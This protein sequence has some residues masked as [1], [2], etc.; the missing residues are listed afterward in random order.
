MSSFTEGVSLTCAGDFSLSGGLIESD[1]SIFLSA[2][3]YLSLLDVTLKAPTVTLN[4]ASLVAVGDQTLIDVAGQAVLSTRAAGEVAVSKTMG[5]LE[6]VRAQPNPRLMDWATLDIRAGS[7]V[8]FVPE[9]NLRTLFLLGLLSMG[10]VITR[11]RRK[12]WHP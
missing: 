2:T 7:S 3:G 12:S 1:Q 10:L 11:Q 4:S 5:S 9:P 6:I 8:Q